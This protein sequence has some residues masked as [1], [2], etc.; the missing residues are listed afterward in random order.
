MGDVD[1]MSWV[2]HR[3]FSGPHSKPDPI[4][5]AESGDLALTR[6]FENGKPGAR[7]DRC[8]SLRSQE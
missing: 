1:A 7:I 8:V 4:E 6:V 2:R 3:E 5:L